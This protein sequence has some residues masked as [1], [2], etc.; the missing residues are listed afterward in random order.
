[1]FITMPPVMIA[2][3]A[4]VE[5]AATLMKHEN[6]GC[7]IVVKNQNADITPR[8]IITDR[9]IVMHLLANRIDSWKVSVK[10]IMSTDLLTLKAEQDIHEAIQA[11]SQRGVRRAPVLNDTGGAIGLISLDDILPL[12]IGE[13]AE[14]AN[15]INKQ[16]K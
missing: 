15:L 4:S 13:L 9:D 6:V 11:M 7:V 8:G 2:E 3:D 1:M 12:L 10:D 5:E 16:K 14:I